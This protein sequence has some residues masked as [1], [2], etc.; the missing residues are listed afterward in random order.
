MLQHS[1]VI[2]QAEIIF[3]HRRVFKGR[4]FSVSQSVQFP[5]AFIKIQSICIKFLIVHCVCFSDT[6]LIL[7]CNIRLAVG[8]GILIH[9]LHIVQHVKSG[10]PVSCPCTH[11]QTVFNS[12]T[13]CVRSADQPAVPFLC[14]SGNL[15]LCITSADSPSTMPSGNTS[16]SCSQRRVVVGSLH[17]SSHIAVFYQSS[18]LCFP[19]NSSDSHQTSDR[20]VQRRAFADCRIDKSAGKSAQSVHSV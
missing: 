20:N 18:F 13:S 4:S 8:T 19:Y 15:S 14:G 17:F 11:A 3:F 12:R 6:G 16:G 2:G 1:A 5:D 9:F 7:F 10:N